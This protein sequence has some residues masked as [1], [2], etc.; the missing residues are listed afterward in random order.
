MTSVPDRRVNR[1]AGFTLLEVVIVMA[2]IAI[3]SSVAVVSMAFYI[4]SLRLKSAA[5]DINVQIQKARLEAIRTSQRCGVK[6]FHTI[7][8]IMYAPVIWLEDNTNDEP[9]AGEKIIYRME[10]SEEAP[11]LRA[12]RQ[13]GGIRY[14]NAFGGDGVT[15]GDNKIVFNRRG[16]SDKSGSI[17]LYNARGQTR[18]VLV[19]LG[20]AVRVY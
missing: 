6:F 8:G 14:N 13:Y 4:P 7:D 16:M 19:T 11:G 1:K 5:Q 18:Q 17:Y 12:M 15:F 9:D 3:L 2:M 10:V 20:G